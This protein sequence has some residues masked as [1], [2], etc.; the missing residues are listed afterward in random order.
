MATDYRFPRKTESNVDPSQGVDKT[1]RLSVGYSQTL[2]Q[3][4]LLTREYIEDQFKNTVVKAFLNKEE[5]Q[6]VYGALYE[7]GYKVPNDLPIY[8]KAEGAAELVDKCKITLGQAQCVLLFYPSFPMKAP[9]KFVQP[10]LR[11][12]HEVTYTLREP[13]ECL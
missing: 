6:K 1:R 9:C 13:E 3:N 8:H 4:K 11:Y 5:G 7:A 2:S 10:K 12:G